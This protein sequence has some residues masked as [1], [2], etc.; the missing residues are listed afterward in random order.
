M[1]LTSGV[2]KSKRTAYHPM[3]NVIV[4][5]L[6]AGKHDQGINSEVKAEMASDVA[7]TR[8]C[9]KLYQPQI[10]QLCSVLSDVWQDP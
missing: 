9:L 7:D 5:P 4:E 8:L 6:D 10:D 2:K 3:G 1:L